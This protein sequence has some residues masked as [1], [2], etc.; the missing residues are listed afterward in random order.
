S[1]VMS[2]A[3]NVMHELT[4][5]AR[6]NKGGGTVATSFSPDDID[7]MLAEPAE[8][9]AADMAG[10]HDMEIAGGEMAR[11]AMFA[12]PVGGVGLDPALAGR[13]E[14]MTKKMDMLLESIAD[15][16]ENTRRLNDLIG[17]G[18]RMKEISEKTLDEIR[19]MSTQSVEQHRLLQS[20]ASQISE[21]REVAIG[22]GR[23]LSE[24]KENFTKLSKSSGVVELIASSIGGQTALLEA[25]IE[26][27]RRSQQ[28][29][30]VI[31]KS[32]LERR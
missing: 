11:Q 1:R 24:I 29:L 15:N 13:F 26:E 2:L 7:A 23:H 27:V 31:N 20:L 10:R 14:L 6:E 17:F 25:L 12:G 8:S 19:H 28:G 21:S 3:R 16:T 4:E 18:P 32:I 5:M 30:A 9:A 22:S